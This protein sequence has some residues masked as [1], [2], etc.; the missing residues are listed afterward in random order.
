MSGTRHST[1][2]CLARM[3]AS[4]IASL[5]LVMAACVTTP[6]RAASEFIVVRHAEKAADGSRDPALSTQGEVRAQALSQ[7]LRGTQ[8]VAAYATPYRRTQ[9]TVQP[10]AGAHG[11]QVT[12]YD[13]S[14]PAAELVAQL[15]RAHSTGTVLVAGHSNTVPQIVSQ[16]C[17]CAVQPLEEDDYG[18]LYRVSFDQDGKAVLSHDRF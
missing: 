12:T 8:L 10:A 1:H 18:D 13:A 4:A 11:L 5:L 15:R 6:Q 17:A 3:R 2:R 7:R 14:L 16:L 9:Q